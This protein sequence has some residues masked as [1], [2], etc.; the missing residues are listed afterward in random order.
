MAPLTTQYKI[1]VADCQIGDKHIQI[2]T[3]VAELTMVDPNCTPE[4]WGWALANGVI[5][6]K[7]V[8]A[9]TAPTA[10]DSEPDRSAEVASEA[11]SVREGWMAEDERERR[12]SED[13][14]VL[15][16]LRLIGRNSDPQEND[17]RD[18][19]QAMTDLDIDA[20]RIGQDR[21]IIEEALLLQGRRARLDDANQ[22]A[23]ST[24]EEY[25]LLDKRHEAE[26][27]EAYMKKETAY[28]DANQCNAAEHLLLKLKRTRPL[29]FTKP[30]EGP[31]RLVGTD[32]TE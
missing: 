7:P 13:G 28:S 2:D 3:L 1:A 8:E 31:I 11:L 30:T 6:D 20:D 24:R 19:A 9:P 10:I 22:L 29:L 15:T 23:V 12:E 32:P 26:E 25:R 4:W 27:H 18:L 14:S 5:T 21:Q 16:Y 17:A